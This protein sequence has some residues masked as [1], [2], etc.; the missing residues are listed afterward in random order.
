MKIIVDEHI[1][2][3]V[4]GKL[5]PLMPGIETEVAE[6]VID[7][8]IQAGIQL[9]VIIEEPEAEVVEEVVQVPKRKKR[10]NA[11]RRK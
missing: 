2:V 5:I 1:D 4:N 3:A 11:K 7:V 6:G 10:K 9:N 8:L